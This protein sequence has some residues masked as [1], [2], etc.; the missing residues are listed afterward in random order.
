MNVNVRKIVLFGTM[1]LIV[2]VLPILAG[3][4]ML[5]GFDE[6]S[7]AN[8][9]EASI[10]SHDRVRAAMA[11]QLSEVSRTLE[12]WS[13]WDAMHHFA[14][15]PTDAQWREENFSAES[16]A[17]LC[18][19]RIA[20]FGPGGEHILHSDYNH[21]EG[22]AADFGIGPGDARLLAGLGPHSDLSSIRGGLCAGPDG[23]ISWALVKPIRKSDKT[24][25]IAGFLM[26]VRPLNAE[27]AHRISSLSGTTTAPAPKGAYSLSEPFINSAGER[28]T[29]LPVDAW[30]GQSLGSLLVSTPVDSIIHRDR[31]VRG[32]LVRIL[33]GAYVL[34]CAPTMLAVAAFWNRRGEDGTTLARSV[35]VP[36]T[37]AA[38]TGIA[39]TAAG[40]WGVMC[41]QQQIHRT[42]FARRAGNYTLQIDREI[43]RHREALE[44][45]RAYY[46]SSV[47]VDPD[48]FERLITNAHLMLPGTS[49]WAWIPARLD[50]SA[51]PSDT[52]VASSDGENLLACYPASGA[53]G[54]LDQL[55]AW[56]ELSPAIRE[57]RDSGR[58]VAL[59]T[60]AVD[61]TD[62]ASRGVALIA[63]VYTTGVSSLMEHRRRDF[64]GL[65]INLTNLDEVVRAAGIDQDYGGIDVA[66]SATTRRPSI[67][68]P[69]DDEG[70]LGL[71][72]RCTLPVAQGLSVDLLVL[73]TRRFSFGFETALP[74]GVAALG[75]IITGLLAAFIGLTLH[76]TRRIAQLVDAR[77]R[78]LQQRSAELLSANIAAEAAH[79]TKSA[80]L[81]NMSH[82]LRTPMTAILGYADLLAEHEHAPE[83]RGE[84]VQIIRRSAQ[85][86]LALINDVLDLSKIEAGRMQF[87]LTPCQLPVLVEDVLSILRDKAERKGIILKAEYIGPVPATI[88]TDPTR[89]R[90]ILVN[91]V[92]NAIK[93]T[94]AG[95]VRLIARMASTA[96]A[97]QPQMT[98]EVLDSGPGISQQVMERLFRPF[99]QGD[100]S[101][102]R[103]F[104]GTG[105]GLSISRQLAQLLGGSIEASSID[106][107]GSSFRFTFRTGPLTGIDMLDAA[108]LPALTAHIASA[109]EPFPLAVFP[110][111][112]P[113]VQTALQPSTPHRPPTPARIL[114]AEDTLDNQRLL[115]FFL[116]S[117]AGEVVLVSNGE[118]AV[119]VALEAQGGGHPFDV[120]LM[121]IQMPVLDGYAATRAL[122]AAGYTLPIVALTAHASPADKQRCFDAGCDAFLTKPVDRA[123]LLSVCEGYVSTRR[124]AA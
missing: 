50:P 94:D 12:D 102:S 48:E 117:L 14:G 53:P 23:S 77:T 72:R 96:D 65:L 59:P 93:F 67:P 62:S 101:M 75:S 22:H 27:I 20:L 105:L 42:E 28:V 108:S 90:Q 112:A 95:G 40:T 2:A 55:R 89:F 97:P 41:W 13:A 109:P 39:F 21:G 74:L 81:A 47:E 19:S 49:R 92:G 61:S 29:C 106:G 7:A 63:P 80:F 16:V 73:A 10:Q 26:M 8:I 114:L 100:G 79:Q 84:F 88:Q 31:Q 25:P 115:S 66:I 71:I 11:G 9:R 70:E 6:F 51:A 68:V 85:H 38:A 78:E 24:G 116:R 86:L 32:T 37:L 110:P 123:K 76:R 17:S 18:L 91:L 98:I 33:I 111:P 104:G 103:R 34:L 30:D 69:I 46:H 15:D 35:R 64:R 99:E 1:I 4:A 87:E 57:A 122:R 83:A 45:A 54:F 119:T 52:G 58:I 124:L 120:V 60:P 121:D 107:E 82:E 44:F 5:R 56:P 36:V 113:P 3:R 118:E 43:A